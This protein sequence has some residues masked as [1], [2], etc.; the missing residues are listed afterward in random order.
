MTLK[1]DLGVGISSLPPDKLRVASPPPPYTALAVTMD[2][3]FW[4]QIASISG[5]PDSPFVTVSFWTK[6]TFVGP[7]Q[8]FYQQDT[9]AAG[10]GIIMGGQTS[11]WCPEIWQSDASEA[12]SISNSGFPDTWVDNVW[13]HL[14]AYADLNA[15]T[16]SVFMDGADITGTLNPSGVSA[17]V[18]FNGTDFAIVPP[19]NTAPIPCDMADF[20]W[21][22]GQ[23]ITNIGLFRDTITGKPKNPS[24]FPGGAAVGLSGNASVF[25]NNTFGTLGPLTTQASALTNAST[26]PS[27]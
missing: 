2:G 3:T 27:S 22:P 19:L 24:G 1:L 9:P 6:A 8:W 11:G 5:V 20:F 7:A 23:H 4:A 26:S 15:Q 13:H 16:T 10:N 12:D 21:Y 14:F 18:V 17:T 25:L